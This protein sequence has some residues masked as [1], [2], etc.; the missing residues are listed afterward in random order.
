MVAICLPPSGPAT[1][2]EGDEDR[3]EDEQTDA[4]TDKQGDDERLVQAGAAL[5]W[6]GRVTLLLATKD[7]WR[8]E[9]IVAPTTLTGV[10]G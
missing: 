2:K 3:E 7:E 1:D 9:F 10:D 8:T 5:L 4:E 6:P